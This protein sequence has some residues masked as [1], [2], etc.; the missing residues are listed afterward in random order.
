MKSYLIIDGYNLLYQLA[1]VEGKKLDDLDLEEQRDKLVDRIANYAALSG[2]ETELVFDAWV[3]GTELNKEEL[4]G[5][6]VVFTGKDQ[7]A[8]TYIES[9]LYTRPRLAHTIL[10]T[11]DSQIQTMALLTGAERISSR[12]FLTMLEDSEKQ[13]EKYHEK[14][15]AR[16]H[17]TLGDYLSEE[18]LELFEKWRKGED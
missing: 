9:Y 5:I 18:G 14:E 2:H 7:T 6:T 16:K 11:G 3:S 13:H 10:V 1:E 12:Q 17:H 8:D 4:S 15:T